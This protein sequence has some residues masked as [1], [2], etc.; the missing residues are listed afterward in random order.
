MAVEF[1][2]VVRQ[3]R[4]DAEMTQTTLAERAYIHPNFIG[5]VE[6]GERMVSLATA[7]QI[8]KGLDVPLSKI[9]VLLEEQSANTSSED[10]SLQNK[11][12]TV[13]RPKTKR[14]KK[15]GSSSTLQIPQPKSR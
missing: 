8:A 2:A 3:L 5:F 12:T 7:A 13:Q 10:A 6:R 9:I 11:A 4:N 14:Q 1:G 15:N